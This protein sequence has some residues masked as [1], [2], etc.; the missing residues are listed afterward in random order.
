MIKKTCCSV[1]HTLTHAT[2]Y[3]TRSYTESVHHLLLATGGGALYVLAV[4]LFSSCFTCEAC[5]QCRNSVSVRI[6]P[7]LRSEVPNTSSSCASNNALCGW[8]KE[9]VG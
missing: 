9:R 5:R 6:L 2:Q 8:K 7:L 3:T 4:T 1:I